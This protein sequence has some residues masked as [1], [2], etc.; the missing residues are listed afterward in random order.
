[1]L[2]TSKEQVDIMLQHMSHVTR[3][4]KMAQMEDY[5]FQRQKQERIIAFVGCTGT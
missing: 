1:M 2:R 5:R 3:N 4:M